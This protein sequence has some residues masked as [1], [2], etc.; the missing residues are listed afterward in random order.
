MT[1]TVT[2]DRM[3]VIATAGHVDHGKSTLLRRLTGMEPDR[4]DEEQRRGLTIDLGFVW[5]QVVDAEGPLWIAF[6]DVPGHHRF[7]DNMLAGVG[8]VRSTLLVVAADDGWSAQSGEH[9]AILDLLGVHGVAVAVTKTDTV[10]PQRTAD[11]TAE[12]S[13]RLRGTA[14]EDTPVVPI[15]S[16]TGTGLPEL[17]EVVHRRLAVVPAE[18]DTGRPRLWVDRAFPVTGAG[19]IV[20]GTLHGGALSVGDSVRLLPSGRSCRIRGLQTLGHARERVPS[21]A[22]LAVNLASV[23]HR[24]VGRG[25]AVVRDGAPWI[26]SDVLEVQLRSV[27]DR[28]LT[29]RGAWQIHIGTAAMTARVRP[30]LDTIAPGETGIARLELEHPVPV[31]YGDRFV[32]REMGR[33]VTVGGG[34]ILDPRPGPRP[35]GVC[36][37]LARSDHLEQVS[38]APLEQVERLL[39]EARGGVTTEEE[40]AALTGSES[41]SNPALVRLS[42]GYLALG[43]RLSDWG[44]AVVEKLQETPSEHGWSQGDLQSTLI[45]AGCPQAAI[46]P[47]LEHLTNNG[48]L[49]RV[50]DQFLAPEQLEAHATV[51][52]VRHERARSAF[53]AA[54]FEP[55]SPE[56]VAS[57][58]GLRSADLQDLVDAGQLVRAGSLLFAAEA[59]PRA[60]ERLHQ[61]FGDMPFSAS[62]ARDVLATSRRYVL[63]LLELLHERGLTRFDGATHVVLCSSGT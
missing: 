53:S 8:G 46:R 2:P 32:L 7:I 40:L 25:D 12:V 57:A 15:D 49:A 10:G 63:P 30:L 35:R 24:T 38:D 60:L 23:S 50:G 11:V 55:P 1:V 33:G 16:I 20:T 19:T 62:Q 45:A 52:R 17:T 44:K 48:H 47:V 41:T 43:L 13:R 58:T 18:P 4:W 34:A 37:R 61:A 14:L 26:C 59:L 21:G 22:R 29:T 9:L 36:N 3:R 5:T 42:N 54:L 27:H 56:D 39:V 28:P 6:V 51:R 31:Q